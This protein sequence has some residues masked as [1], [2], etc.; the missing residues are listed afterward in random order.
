MNVLADGWTLAQ[1]KLLQLRHTPGVLAAM[2]ITPAVFVVVFGFAFG[3]AIHVPGVPDYREY[4]MPGLFV[5]VTG[6][7]LSSSMVDV[8]TDQACAVVKR[9]RSLPM[10]QVS[11]PLGQSGAE[12]IVGVYGLAV[13]M[14]YGLVVG[15]RPHNGLGQ[16]LAGVGLLL[17]FQYTMVWVGA[18]LGL[19]VRSARTA[20]TL[21]PLMVP[22]TLAS[23]AFVPT[24]RM[25]AWLRVI[26]EW[27]PLSAIATAV[28]SLF[29]NPG[30]PGVGASWPLTHPVTAT[31]LWTGV[32][33]AIFVPLSARRFTRAGL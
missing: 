22:L 23:T 3:S 9:L 29:G 26:C 11:V 30:A 24:D 17:L 4:M 10:N 21:A 33:S 18:Y 25:P 28:R 8:A 13:F 20:A 16:T 7:A 12:G 32:L 19:V 6:T 14:V 5:L 1:R 15:W 27:N 2:L 31:L